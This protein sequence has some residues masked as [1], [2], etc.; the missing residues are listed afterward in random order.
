MA[1]RQFY[2]FGPFAI[3]IG[4]GRLERAGEPV[5]LPPKAFDL[6]LLL[7]RNSDRV[8]TKTELMEALWP[9]TFV[10]DANLT[11]HVYTLRK[12]L[13][14]LPNGQPFIDT[15]PRRGYR[16]AVSVR[17]VVAAAPAG[18]AVGEGV[19]FVAPEGERK[20]ATVLDC[21]IANAAAVVEQ[22]GPAAAQELTRDL[23][24]MAA[25][26]LGRYGGVITERS[27]DGF[28]ALFGASIVHED[29]SRRAVLA[30][31]G[32]QQRFERLAAPGLNQDEPLKLRIG[33]STG[34]LVVTRA[35]SH[36]AV[37]Y[38]AVG[39]PARV[40]DLLQ[41]L[42]SPGVALIS[43]TTRRAVD[44]YIE[45]VPSGS[46]GAA[47][48]VFRVV[49]LLSRTDAQAARFARTLAPFVGR[50]QELAV[51]A[52]LAA[53]VRAGKGH[54]VS[55][56]GEPGIGKSRLLRECTQHVAALAGMTV[57]EGQCVSYGSNIPYLPLADLIRD[58]PSES[59][60]S[61][62]RTIGGID[63]SGA[64]EG[65]SP[66]AVKARTFDALRTLFFKAAKLTPLL[67]AVE[68]IH[69][70]DRTS[71]EFLATLVER[72][73]GAPIMVVTTCRPGYRVPWLDRSYFE[74]ITLRPLTTADSAQ[75]VDHVLG[76][77]PLPEAASASIVE[78]GEG[79]PFFL[80]ELA[81]T[82]VERGADSTAIPETVQ[83]VIMAR[84]DRLPEGAKHLLQ[85]AS[86]IGREVPLQLLDQV[87]RGGEH[88]LELEELCRLEFLYE[89]PGA[90]EPA[91]IFKHA[92]TQDVA[93]DSLLART[94]RELHLCT[95]EALIAVYGDR[96]DLAATFA[97]HY[98]R[99]DLVDE[100]VRWLIRAADRAARV[101]ANAE[102]VLHLD[103]AA[104]RLQRLPEKPDRDRRI[105]D[106]ALR[107]AH[108]LYFLGRFRESV[109][110][111]LP[112]EAR[113]ARLNEPASTAAYSFWLAHMH[114]RLGDQRRASDNAA[115]AIE[116][117]TQAG[118]EE[119]LGK[120][121]GLLVLEGHWSGN[122]ADGISH[123][124][125]SLDLL[126][127][128]PQ[129]R[130]WL[131][132][133]H[134]YLAMNHL[135]QGDFEAALADANRV[136][137][138]GKEIGDPRLQTYAAFAVGWVE[139]TR[140]NDAAAVAA[141]QRSRTQAPDRVSRA[142]ASM[143]LGFALIGQGDHAQART[144]LEPVVAELE[145][146]AIPQYHGFAAALTAET[147]RLDARL[148]V[149][150]TLIERALDV[151]TRAQ[152]WY[153]VA[154][155][156]RVAARIA[157]DRGARDEATATLDDAAR[158]FERIGARFEAQHTY[159]ERDRLTVTRPPRERPSPDAR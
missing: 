156:Q 128:H 70:I 27:A 84:V 159:D 13:G 145:G 100:A 93:Y 105:L 59:G 131:G 87:W 41:Q 29:D 60:T 102:A 33:I 106:V 135:L 16:L 91:V 95:A 94:R 88:A 12:A 2:E 122:T 151:M 110:V 67:I 7:A 129:Q 92:L 56:V 15:V 1:D 21:R 37:E 36:A 19:G 73:A 76:E 142:Y 127:A 25:E 24:K 68:D 44:G 139:A 108:S 17:E 126:G 155:A 39:D 42:A 71:E 137:A 51:L 46:H 148:D 112:H 4:L 147:Y 74:Q 97:Y 6:L 66:E 65:L 49:G 52:D 150:G 133:T 23:L 9:N 115:R 30:A 82:V 152:Y 116:A 111:L 34:G 80:E 140:G 103:L 72:L 35:G 113:L 47:G 78:K 28:V 11:Q 57:L 20:R 58:L 153:G 96:D 64:L 143:M 81:R 5:P 63:T 43:D 31:L 3:D 22:L 8:M 50:Q 48:P 55:I 89:K 146:F 61:L 10:E 121:H 130:W 134:F 158:T 77:Q 14:D 124:R 149:A 119:T 26:E 45:T 132:M 107:H 32:I 154:F 144:I 117:A 86:V 62:L 79:N 18:A 69:W 53:R 38:A 138:V 123:G 85:T 54:A 136:D 83:G 90:D 75:L 114:S 101:Y 120:A 125:K 104:R 157:L 40:A 99:T 118:D 141:C 109:E 98:A